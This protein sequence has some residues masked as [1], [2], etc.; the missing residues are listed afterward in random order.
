M[1]SVKQLKRSNALSI[2]KFYFLQ[3]FKLKS[4]NNFSQRQMFFSFNRNFTFN[5][6]TIS[7]LL[8]LKLNSFVINIPFVP[9]IVESLIVSYVKGISSKQKSRP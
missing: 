3:Y 6:K 1:I 4:L 7:S 5:I 2:F 8:K 9:S